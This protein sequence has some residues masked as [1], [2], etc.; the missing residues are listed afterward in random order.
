MPQLSICDEDVLKALFNDLILE[1]ASFDGS[2]FSDTLKTL[3]DRYDCIGLTCSQIGK[4]TYSDSSW[5]VCV[6]RGDPSIILNIAGYTPF[7][8]TS[9]ELSRIDLDVSTILSFIVM[10]VSRD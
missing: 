7:S 9:S 3:Q 5:P 6:D 10:E 1:N 2:K 4:S 8:K